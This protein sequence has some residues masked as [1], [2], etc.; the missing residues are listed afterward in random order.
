MHMTPVIQVLPEKKII[1][2]RITT[3]LSQNTTGELWQGFMASRHLITNPLNQNLFSIEI[4]DRDFFQN[5]SPMNLFEKW[6]GI[7]VSNFESIPDGMDSLSIP[8]G[9][10]AIFQHNGPASKSMETFQYIFQTWLPASD[11]NL[12]TRPHFEIMDDRY[13]NEDPDSEEKLYIPVV[14]K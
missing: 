4:Y 12:D 8:E 9:L 10:Y 1:G 13:K 11:Y 7:E 3:S 14:S 6:A 5:F 2:H